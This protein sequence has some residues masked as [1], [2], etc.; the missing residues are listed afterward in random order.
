MKRILFTILTFALSL[1]VGAQEFELN[2]VWV[3]NE[4]VQN[5]ETLEM[6]EVASVGVYSPETGEFET[7]VE[8]PGA[9]FT[10]NI[11]M[12]DGFAF[13]G[14]DN[15]IVKINLDT[16]YVEAEVEVQGVRQL[17]HHNGLIYMTRGDAD[18]VTWASIDFDSYFMWFDAETLSY[19]GEMPAA[20]GMGYATEGITVKD[21]NIYVAINN[22]FAWAQEVGVLGVYNVEDA[23]YEEYDLGEN[24]KNPAHVKVT[25]NEVLLVNNTDW[26]A[27]SL[28]RIELPALGASEAN[29]NTV[30]VEGVAA[31]CNA[32]AVL[33]EDILFQIGSE[34]GMRK[35]SVTD[36]T[37][38]DGV[39]GPA[40]DNYY[41]MAVEPVSGNVYATVSNFFDTGE[42]HILDSEGNFI[43][44]FTTASVPGG[45][46][47]D[48]RE[49][50]SVGGLEMDLEG[51]VVGEFDLMGRVWSKGNKGFKIERLSNGKINKIYIAR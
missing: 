50:S 35:A 15:K 30:M 10:T 5:W 4:G 7:V 45:V 3:L 18:P 47:F 43:E 21:D 19:V 39:W 25:E 11:I 9:R 34:M 2:A 20:E 49:I 8:F 24:G 51:Q 41:R 46:A 23:G 17:A 31:G 16:Y 12:V 44:S 14:A 29:V 37:P 40:T 26:S 36:L 38:V 48:V 13:V 28:S 1:S 27:T 32:A 22:G 42:V 33:G 6:E